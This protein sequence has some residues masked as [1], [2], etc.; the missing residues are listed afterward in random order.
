MSVFESSDGMDPIVTA[1]RPV[2]GR[3]S[4]INLIS[5][6]EGNSKLVHS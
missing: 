3:T 6:L 4:M 2:S 5:V 1:R